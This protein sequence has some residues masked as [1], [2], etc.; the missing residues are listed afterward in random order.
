MTTPSTLL[1][2]ALAAA[3]RGWPVFPVTPN[4]KFPALHSRERCPGIGACAGGHRGWEQ[5]ATTD[6][7]RI[8]TCWTH[9]D[10]NIGLATGPAGLVVVDL[11]VPKPG[12]TIPPRWAE[13]G[14]TNGMAVF[15]LICA[16][17][18]QEAPL[19][20]FTV[21]THSGGAHLYFRAPAGVKLRNTQGERN[22]LG[23]GIDTRAHGGYVIA[24]GSLRNGH[25]YTI[26]DDRPPAP[27][28]GWL[29]ERL[30]PAELPPQQP[31][32]ITTGQG[33]RARYL[34]AAIRAEVQRVES[35]A[36]GERNFS[37]YCA[38]NAL[39][40]LVA[41]GELDRQEVTELLLRAAQS[42]VAAGAYGW[43]QA[44]KTIA[45]GLRAGAARPRKV[46]A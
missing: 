24:P 9:A 29:V 16:E 21:T 40:Q 17:A 8:R 35:A 14:A 4:G 32:T 41:G 39:G 3:E 34:D 23:W 13:L 6:P 22:G 11:D 31:V 44:H 19:A 36:G 25:R 10:Y 45:S 28:P 46:A 7:A 15:L 27:L 38:A 12:K 42:H 18:G 5:R 43:N 30:R 2:A 37:L 26:T 20:T 33:R 1:D